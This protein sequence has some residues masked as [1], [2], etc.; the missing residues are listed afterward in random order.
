MP[1]ATADI[2]RR[3]KSIGSTKKVTKAMELVSAAK[4]RK[5]I[6]SV[7]STRS[8]SRLAWELLKRLAQ[9]TNSKYHALLKKRPNL[10]KIGLVLI[11]SNRGLCGSFN[12]QIINRA[13]DFIKSQKREIGLEADLV[14]MGKKGKDVMYKQG[15]NII[16]EFSKLDI[17]TAIEEIR[18]LAKLLIDDYLSGKYDKV[19]IAYTDFISTL[20]QK[21]RLMQLLPLVRFNEDKYLGQAKEEKSTTV[22]KQESLLK[23]EYLFE[24]NPE[25][26]LDELLPRMLEM[27]IYQAILESDASEHSARMVAMCNASDSASDM[28]SSLTLAFNKARQSSI[29]SELADI[30]GG[31]AAV[32]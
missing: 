12:Y 27:Q 24:P 6:A 23:F 7:L 32:E 30:S 16:A 8:Y 25:K 14:I 13:H 15:H 20:A 4:M 21:P 9:R 2:K 18:P 29:T 10:K 17:T 26:V 19:M 5:A 11:T 3:I 1:Q 22:E 28:I 31:R